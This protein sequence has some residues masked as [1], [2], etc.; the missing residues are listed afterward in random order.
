MDLVQGASRVCPVLGEMAIQISCPGLYK[1]NL[2]VGF[3]IRVS[4]HAFPHH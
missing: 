3:L 1:V 4:R 2:N